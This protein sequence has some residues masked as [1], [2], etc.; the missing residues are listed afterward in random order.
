MAKK[1]NLR[2]NSSGESVKLKTG[3]CTEVF[4]ILKKRNQPLSP[5]VI[6]EDLPKNTVCKAKNKILWVKYYLRKLMAQ[7][8]V[9]KVKGTKKLYEL[10]AV[11]TSAGLVPS[12]KVDKSG[13]NSLTNLLLPSEDLENFDA[14]E[15]VEIDLD[16]IVN[17]HHGKVVEIA[18][19]DTLTEKPRPEYYYEEIISY[20]F[21]PTLSL[22]KII[23]YVARDNPKAFWDAV[24]KVKAEETPDVS[25]EQ[26]D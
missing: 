24:Q 18:N 10:W 2:T 17:P 7:R 15:D 23:E 25:P 13:V 8:V 14:L 26:D 11:K 3:G 6:S 5:L 9:R 1:F 22:F 20:L 19:H 12:L 16:S 4:D 21:N